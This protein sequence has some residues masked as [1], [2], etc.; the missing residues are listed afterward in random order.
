MNK[1][2]IQKDNVENLLMKFGLHVIFFSSSYIFFSS[3]YIIIQTLLA[4]RRLKKD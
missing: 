3:S 1:Y 2:L 4:K